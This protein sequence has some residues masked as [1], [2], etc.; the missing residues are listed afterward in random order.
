MQPILA[1]E[2][3]GMRCITGLLLYRYQKPI[4]SVVLTILGR[5]RCFLLRWENKIP[6]KPAWAWFNNKNDVEGI[7]FA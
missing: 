1:R 5:A 4:K 7:D 2:W 6:C 3:D